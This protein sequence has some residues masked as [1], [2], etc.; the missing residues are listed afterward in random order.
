VRLRAVRV[1]LTTLAT[2]SA[3]RALAQGALGVRLQNTDFDSLAR[4][5]S[6]DPSEQPGPPVGETL[7]RAQHP[8]E[9]RE[10]G[11]RGSASLRV[12]SNAGV[13]VRGAHLVSES[14]AGFGRACQRTIDRSRWSAPRARNGD[15][16]A[17][18]IVYTCH[19]EVD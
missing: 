15:A 12:R 14:S 6:E 2:L 13:L 9:A 1:A 16:V 5:S 10:R 8:G 19:F 3:P 18:E 7:L 17:I 11:L 4:V